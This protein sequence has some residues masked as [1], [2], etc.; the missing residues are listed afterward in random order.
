M[1]PSVTHDRTEIRNSERLSQFKCLPQSKALNIGARCGREKQLLWILLKK[2]MVNSVSR[3]ES[4]GHL[5]AA[6]D[7]G[8]GGERGGVAA[9]HPTLLERPQRTHCQYVYRLRSNSE[10][11][12]NP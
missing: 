4:D 7:V 9:V 2:L 10:F 12:S 3:P 5:V 1:R 11:K 8:E 6:R